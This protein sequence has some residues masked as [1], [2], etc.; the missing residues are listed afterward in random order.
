[1][2]IEQI[3]LENIGSYRGPN[4]FDLSINSNE[5]NVILIGGEN[6]AGKTTFLNSIRLGLFGSYGYGYKTE[7]KEYFNQVYSF[8]NANARKQENELFS[9]TILFNE[10]ENY[11]RNSYTFKRSWSLTGG[12]LK[13]KFTIL[14]DG[15]HLNDAE[16]D[17]YQS[18]LKD[19]F[20]PK[21]LIY[22]Y[23]MVKKYLEL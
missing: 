6:G 1:M 14:K 20:P 16:T 10:V 7:N 13:E 9:I 22:V 12:N 4:L 17:I 8:L 23:L 18:K 19:T 15:S 21:L 11:R 2:L 3:I 5:K